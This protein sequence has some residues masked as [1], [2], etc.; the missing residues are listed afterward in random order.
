MQVLSAFSFHKLMACCCAGY[1]SCNCVI[2]KAV[3]A[4][5]LMGRGACADD[6]DE[7]MLLGTDQ[8]RPDFMTPAESDAQVRTGS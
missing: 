8:E 1:L 6:V 5:M 4:C 7:V 3:L 2:N